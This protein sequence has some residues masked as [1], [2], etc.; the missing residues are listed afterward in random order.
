MDAAGER[1]GPVRRQAHPCRHCP[2][3]FIPG[4]QLLCAG[5]KF[6]VADDAG[7][8]S[9]GPS[10]SPATLQPLPRSSASGSAG[11]AR[12]SRVTDRQTA[13]AAVAGAGGGEAFEKLIE[14]LDMREDRA[15]AARD[16][17]AMFLSAGAPKKREEAFIRA[18]VMLLC[19]AD[20]EAVQAPRARKHV[21][22]IV[23]VSSVGEVYERYRVKGPGT[24]RK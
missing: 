16:G 5:L 11:T 18:A 3:P 23:G 21:Q 4:H 12:S 6:E 10:V 1:G 22:M 7:R 8:R 19:M 9:K 20:P 2:L 17:L 15:A 14:A 24:R 13:S